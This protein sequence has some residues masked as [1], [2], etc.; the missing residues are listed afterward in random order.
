MKQ[1]QITNQKIKKIQKI[2]KINQK[3]YIFTIEAIIVMSLVLS[4]IILIEPK[5]QNKEKELLVI[6]KQ[7]DL[8]KI[9]SLEG[10]EE[11]DVE[12]YLGK[13]TK[14]EINNIDNRAWYEI[15]TIETNDEIKN[16]I[17]LENKNNQKYKIIKNC[18]IIHTKYSSTKVCLETTIEN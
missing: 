4:T 8:F 17:F 7:N 12:W 6:Q 1:T 2:Q 11:N 16:Q 9:W 5:T 3:G 14:I 15:K 10:I 13:N 18:K